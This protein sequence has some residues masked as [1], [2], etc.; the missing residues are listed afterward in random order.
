MK[1]F[2]ILLL[3]LVMVFAVQA[4][5]AQTS[6]R[7]QR[8]I[9]KAEKKRLKEEEQRKNHELV[10]SLVKDKTYV[11]EATTL[12]GRY[13]YQ[14]QVSPTTNFVKIEGDQIVVQTANNFGI[15]Y[16]GLGGI[17]INGTIRDYQITN[18]K[19]GVTVFIRF[20]DPVMGMST[21]N[22]SIQ[23]SG[24]ARAT[25]LG[26]WGARATFQGQFTDLEESRVYKGRS[27][28]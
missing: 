25:V 5:W 24:Y 7:E 20:A 17:T 26:N 1:I 23:E 12:S 6:S 8:K 27:I 15:G 2:R 21:L 13:G 14:Y 18:E 4:G 22:M 9:E 10:I 3:G 11:L 28:I 16:N 19:N